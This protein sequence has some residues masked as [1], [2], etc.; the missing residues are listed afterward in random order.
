MKDY[1]EMAQSVFRRRE[2]YYAEKKRLRRA[3]Q[4]GLACCCI[5]ALGVAVWNRD[6][7]FPFSLPGERQPSAEPPQAQKEEAETTSSNQIPSGHSAT[8]SPYGHDAA[9]DPYSAVS[10]AALTPDSAAFF[11]GSYLDADGTFVIVLTADTPENRSAICEELGVSEREARF[12]S[13]AYT[14]DYLTE[15]QHT[16]SAAMAGGKLPFVTSS[17]VYETCN[18]VKVSVTAAQETEIAQL[19]A[20]DSLGGAIEI[21]HASSAAEDALAT[22]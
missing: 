7:L 6:L 16:I 17:G 22:E 12:E 2:Q 18:R 13:G 5:A 19:L 1:H 21:E 20:L 11:G 10:S 3:V 8:A 4:K 14:L 15:L 9:A